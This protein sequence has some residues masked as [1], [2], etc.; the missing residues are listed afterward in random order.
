MKNVILSFLTVL[1]LGVYCSRL[2]YCSRLAAQ[3]I[4][5]SP[6]HCRDLVEQAFKACLASGHSE[7]DCLKLKEEMLR[8]CDDMQPPPPPPPSPL[9]CEEACKLLADKVTEDCRRHGGTEEQCA[10]KAQEVLNGCLTHCQPPPP[11]PPPP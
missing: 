1:C 4:D 3:I 9:T 8:R 10:A 5:M 11:P 2:N 7:A 6:E